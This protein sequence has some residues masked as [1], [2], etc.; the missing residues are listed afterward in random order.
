MQK[1]NGCFPRFFVIQGVEEPRQTKS[2]F[3]IAKALSQ[4]VGKDYSAKELPNGDVL[5]EVDNKEQST[6]IMQLA[7][8]EETNVTVTTL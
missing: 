3:A 8:V 5:A 2:S 6:K 4:L 7:Q 1:S